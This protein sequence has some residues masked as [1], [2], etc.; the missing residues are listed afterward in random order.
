VIGT[1]VPLTHNHSKSEAEKIKKYENLT[2]KIEN[3]W[4]LNNMSTHP[5][6]M[7]ADAVVNKPF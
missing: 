1:A 4:K 7:T 6:V 2:L 5:L 3:I